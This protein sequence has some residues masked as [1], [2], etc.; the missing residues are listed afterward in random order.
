MVNDMKEGPRASEEATGVS[1]L[2]KNLGAGA[3]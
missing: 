1:G 2:D 3:L